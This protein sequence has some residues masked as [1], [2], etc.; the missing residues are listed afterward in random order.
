MPNA[1]VSSGIGASIQ[2]KMIRMQVLGD[3]LDKCGRV[4]YPNRKILSDPNKCHC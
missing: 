4:Y 1:K 2:E 3:E